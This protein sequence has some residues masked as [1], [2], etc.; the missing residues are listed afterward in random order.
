VKVYSLEKI[1]VFVAFLI[2]MPF[3]AM[4]QKF[5]IQGIIFDNFN[6]PIFN[7]LITISDTENVT[8][9][10]GYKS[11]DINGNFKIILNSDLKLDSIWVNVK[12]IS[13]ETVRL[14]LPFKN[15]EKDIILDTKVE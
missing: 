8:N 2:G 14:K 10:L 5:E 4:A 13:Y 9:I 11:S 15:L 12:H 7:C 3:F 6:K 1:I